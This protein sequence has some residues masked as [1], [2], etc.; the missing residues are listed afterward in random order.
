MPGGPVQSGLPE[1]ERLRVR[2]AVK[3]QPE[4]IGRIRLQ[5]CRLA[6]RDEGDVR[7]L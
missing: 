3:E 2:V 1:V 7:I 6:L 4:I 5:L